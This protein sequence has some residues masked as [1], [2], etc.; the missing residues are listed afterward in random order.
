[1]LHEGKRD[2]AF[3]LLDELK[4]VKTYDGLSSQIQGIQ[5]RATATDSGPVPAP[6][7]ERIDKMIDM[8]RVLM[9]KYLQDD[10]V[11]ELEV[12]L[13]DGNRA[14]SQPAAPPAT[15]PDPATNSAN[16]T[17]VATPPAP[18]ATPTPPPPSGAGAGPTP[19]ATPPSTSQPPSGSGPPRQVT[20]GT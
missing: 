19:A 3:T 10:I 7:A 17:P 18:A 2:E 14:A 1:M 8:T 4:K 6:V 12:K 16:S 5:R 11:R 20:S 13:L 15:T 9:Q